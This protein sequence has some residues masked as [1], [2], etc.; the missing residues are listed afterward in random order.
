[1]YG[2]PE[3]AHHYN[4]TDEIEQY[5]IYPYVH[6]FSNMPNKDALLRPIRVPDVLPSDLP[7]NT[8]FSLV[9]G[10]FEEVYGKDEWDEDDPASGQWDA[11]V[12]CFFIDTVRPSFAA[13]AALL[14]KYH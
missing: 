4:R 12:T 10:D 11:I 9:A 13:L 5:T 14:T 3:D 6:S 8:N 2:A 7:P 1:M